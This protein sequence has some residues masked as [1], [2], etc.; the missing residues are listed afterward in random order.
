MLWNR[1]F[2]TLYQ[3]KCSKEQRI[4]G[5]ELQSD[6]KSG[7]CKTT[8]ETAS[9]MLDAAAA[10]IRDLVV[11]EVNR[12]PV[13]C[14]QLDQLASGNLALLGRH[15]PNSRRGQQLPGRL[16]E[17]G[18]LD[19]PYIMAAAFEER[20]ARRVPEGNLCALP[21]CRVLL[22]LIGRQIFPAEI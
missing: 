19:I 11:D 9:V 7:D 18:D 17:S 6:G 8:F 5:R 12:F 1:E 22:T 2:L 14:W 10:T 21:L 13:A 15:C 4:S 16:L 3:G 20:N